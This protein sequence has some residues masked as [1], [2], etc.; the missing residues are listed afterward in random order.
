MEY[1]GVENQCENDLSVHHIDCDKR[2]LC[3]QG[4][5]DE[6]LLHSG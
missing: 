4:H 6:E 5:S 3:L 2:L 1:H